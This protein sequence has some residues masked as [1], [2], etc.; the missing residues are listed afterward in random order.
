MNATKNDN[1]VFIVVDINDNKFLMGDVL[2]AAVYAGSPDGG[3]TGKTTASRAGMSA[4]FTY[5]TENIYLYEGNI[6][7][8]EATV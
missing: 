4:E 3:G 5:K 8:T 6:P 7:L 2:L 1:L